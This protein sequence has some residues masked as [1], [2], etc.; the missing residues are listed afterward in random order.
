[1]VG[2]EDSPNLG[3]CIFAVVDNDLLGDGHI[4]CVHLKGKVV[5][6]VGVVKRVLELQV[7]LLVL[8]LQGQEVIENLTENY[9]LG[10]GD[11]NQDDTQDK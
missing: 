9:Y 7:L 10:G 4:D 2:V 8:L 3:S 11:K 6:G 1:M 5:R